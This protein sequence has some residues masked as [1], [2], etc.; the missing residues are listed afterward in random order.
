M[1]REQIDI[2]AMTVLEL[3]DVAAARGVTVASLLDES[4]PQP[5]ASAL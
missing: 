2:Q 1:K 5:A 3:G 4:G